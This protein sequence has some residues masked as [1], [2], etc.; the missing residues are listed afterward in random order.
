LS[1]SE[2]RVALRPATMG[3]T[4][5]VF[6][7]RND[8][9]IVAR[10]SSQKIVTWEEHVRWFQTTIAGSERKMFIVL[11]DGEPAGQ[12]RFDRIDEPTCAIS[13]YVLEKF[14]GR[15]LGVEAI[16]RGCDM[17]FSEWQVAK[18]VACVRE[19]NAAGR[20]GFRKAGFVETAETSVCPPRHFTL[21]LKRGACDY[22]E[23]GCL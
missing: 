7:W 23:A 3:D 12:I 14:T 4:Q 11:V 13:A 10:G 17:L 9:F 18:I 16:R 8:P 21:V 1:A 20:A 5:T 19:D 22:A 2:S 6:S 15:G